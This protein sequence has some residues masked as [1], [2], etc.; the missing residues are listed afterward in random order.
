MGHSSY[1]LAQY[2]DDANHIVK[3]GTYVPEVNAYVK[4]I[5]GQGTAK[6]GFFGM[7]R[8]TSAITTFHVKTASELARTAPSLGITP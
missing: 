2:V 4:L 7:E 6:C 8:G 1:T 5:G 3:T